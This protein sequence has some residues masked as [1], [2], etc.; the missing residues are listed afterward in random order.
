[1]NLNHPY[2]LVRDVERSVAFYR[3]L[4]AFD[5]PSEWQGETFVIRNSEGFSLALAP[6]PG[7]RYPWPRICTQSFTLSSSMTRPAPGGRISGRR[8]A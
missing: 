3:D 6:D 1:M 5:G 8:H 2:L 4:F 7:G